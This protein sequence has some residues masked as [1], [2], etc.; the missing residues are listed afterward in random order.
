MHWNTTY[1]FAAYHC[2]ALEFSPIKIESN[3]FQLTPRNRG[4]PGERLASCLLRG[5]LFGA[6]HC[7]LRWSCLAALETGQV[8]TKNCWQG[9]L[10]APLGC[11]SCKSVYW[12]KAT[13][14]SRD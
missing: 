3:D 13:K 5:L 4:T 10:L 7:R 12:E 2:T 1:I 11:F 6:R 9:V 14:S 8:P